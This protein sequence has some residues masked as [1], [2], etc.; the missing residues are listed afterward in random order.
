M[1]GGRREEKKMKSIV[2]CSSVFTDDPLRRSHLWCDISSVHK[3]LFKPGWALLIS[4][5]KT[6]T[7]REQSPHFPTRWSP[8]P[9]A[10]VGWETT[11]QAP[12]CGSTH[13]WILSQENIKTV[14]GKD[15]GNDA[16]MGGGRW[17]WRRQQRSSL[18]G[19]A[20]KLGHFH[21]TV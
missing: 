3:G 8:A 19:L 15:S 20:I 6:E 16:K 17:G 18:S 2:R 1:V 10:M 5:S 11:D 9:S 14:K 4:R 7:Y 21:R 12:T 13:H